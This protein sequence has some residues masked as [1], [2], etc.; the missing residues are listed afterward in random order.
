[1][2][3]VQSTSALPVG[4]ICVSQISV[5]DAEAVGVVDDAARLFGRRFVE[6]NAEDGFIVMMLWSRRNW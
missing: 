2:E 1:M 6:V 4:V 3:I 5:F